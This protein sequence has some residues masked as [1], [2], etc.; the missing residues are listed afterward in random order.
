MSAAARRLGHVLLATVG[1][2]IRVLTELWH[3]RRLNAVCL[4]DEGRPLVRVDVQVLD[5]VQEVLAG[6][7]TDSVQSAK[8]IAL[9]V[10]DRVKARSVSGDMS[11]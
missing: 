11:I 7:A 10:I 9:M 1:A 2:R 3:R 8:V 6:K 5:R 4:G